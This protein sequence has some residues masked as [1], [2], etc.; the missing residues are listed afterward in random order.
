MPRERP[1]IEAASANV[2]RLAAK[3]ADIVE[4]ETTVAINPK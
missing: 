2:G 4:S 1:S 3:T